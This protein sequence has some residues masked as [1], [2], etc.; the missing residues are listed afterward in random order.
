MLQIH[1]IVKLIQHEI[2][3]A[4]LRELYVHQLFRDPVSQT[5]VNSQLS[6]KAPRQ[7]MRLRTCNRAEPY[8]T[9]PGQTPP[10]Y[11]WLSSFLKCLDDSIDAHFLS[12]FTGA[13]T[14]IK[15]KKL[16]T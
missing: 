9:F 1:S 8:G 12:C 15:E 6:P 10:S 16:T 11:P 3:L 7:Q 14:T 13:K 2:I 5:T 4:R